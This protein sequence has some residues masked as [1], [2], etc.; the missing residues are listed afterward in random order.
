MTESTATIGVSAVARTLHGRHFRRLP[1]AQSP[2][3]SA[4]HAGGV[5]VPEAMRLK[6]NREENPKPKRPLADAGLDNDALENLLDREI[7]TSVAKQEAV[8][9]LAARRAGRAIKADRKTVHYSSRRQSGEPLPGRLR[10]LGREQ[11]RYRYR[12]HHGLL[13]AEGHAP[14]DEKTQHLDRDEGS[15]ARK[16][17]D[18]RRESGSR[19]DPGRSQTEPAMVHRLRARPVLERTTRPHPQ[20]DPRG[21]QGM[22]GGDR[23]NVNLWQA[24]RA[25]TRHGYRLARQTRPDRVRSRDSAHLQCDAGVGPGK[26]HRL[27]FDRARKVDAER[28]L[29]LFNGRTRGELLNETLFHDLD[30]VRPQMDEC[31]GSQQKFGILDLDSGARQRLVRRNAGNCD[32]ECRSCLRAYRA[33][34]AYVEKRRIARSRMG[35]D[36]PKTQVKLSVI[37][38]SSDSGHSISYNQCFSRKYRRTKFEP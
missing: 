13:R 27:A 28:D 1:L 38:F 21:H 20:R 24:R 31:M 17:K 25:R 10:E 23:R 15:T 14:N 19:A 9:Y 11:R 3:A 37:T 22:S 16:R 36:E 33:Y 18:R 4:P 8:G 7:L 30:H 5:V 35:R 34:V 2:V 26:S 6:Q 12:R 32:R 29:R